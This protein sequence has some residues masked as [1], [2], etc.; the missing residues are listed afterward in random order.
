MFSSGVTDC[1]VDVHNY[2]LHVSQKRPNAD[3]LQG[4]LHVKSQKRLRT[5]TYRGKLGMSQGVKSKTNNKILF[6]FQFVSNLKLTHTLLVVHL[7][8]FLLYAKQY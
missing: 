3:I 1:T 6:P 2:I 7:G 5:R 4:R 8:G